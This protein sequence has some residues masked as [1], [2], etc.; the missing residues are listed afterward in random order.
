MS[1]RPK[2]WLLDSHY[3]IFRAYYAMPD[4]RAPDGTPT[5]A[6]RGYAS[7]LVKLF[8]L[9]RPTHVAAAWDHALT[10]FRNE[11][12]DG[13]K[14][15]RTEAP[16]DLEPQF[17]LCEEVTRALGVPVFGLERFEADDVIATMTARALDEGAEVV[18]ASSDKDL[19]ALVSDRVSLF[20]PRSESLLGPA[21]VEARLGVA[22]DLVPDFLTLVGDAVDNIPGVPGIGAKTA[23]RLLRRFGRIE[24]I[25]A[26]P[27][28][29]AGLGL[30]GAERVAKALAEGKQAIAL[31]RKLV[32]MREDLPI[33]ARV[34]ELRWWGADRPVLESFC[35]RLG[36]KG[37]VERVP[38]FRD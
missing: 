35:A 6:L 14:A 4:L 33:R 19:G 22:P 11:L 16:A 20:D 2:L 3:Q 26:D 12:H 9:Q 29:W 17:A 23:A 25:P 27:L 21:E 7:Q 24:D 13:Y 28:E 37:L 10:S 36:L 18:I 31:A 34:D 8:T 38:R 5:G 15:G 1:D 30:R 32:R